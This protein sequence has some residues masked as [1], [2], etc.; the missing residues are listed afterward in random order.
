MPKMKDVASLAGVSPA[1][2]SRVLN[3][4]ANV[5][6]ALAERVRDA[7][8]QLDYRANGVARSLRLQRT[9]VW[10]LII[11]DIEN[12]F[13]TS[14]ARG[15]EDI[16]Q[17]E[18]F[19]VILCNTDGNPEKEARYLDVAEREQVSGVVISPNRSG[20]D[21]SRLMAA[22]IPIVAVDRHLDQPVDTVVVDSEHGA[23]EATR[24]LFEQGWNRPACVTGPTAT[25]T[26]EQRLEGY[27]RAW[28]AHRGRPLVSLVKHTD[29]NAETAR[30]A[31]ASLLRQANPPDSFFVANSLMALGALE[32]FRE[33][34]VVPGRDVGL[35]AFDDAPWA[36]FVDPPLSVV[37][38]P[39]YDMGCR[40]GELLLE[41]VRARGAV[42]PAET[43]V[44]ETSLVPRA[45]S[46]RSAPTKRGR[47]RP[48]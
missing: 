27:R 44:L 40:A 5:D 36:R 29:Y 45:S 38:Q 24:H 20:S 31:V 34:G 8:R 19:S 7:A 14:V 22:S 23:E 9:D 2:V 41:R 15:V 37:A 48:R 39:A 47:S 11:S 46:R 25:E 30:T 12:P 4:V 32:E 35:I 6:E 33:R 42:R 43:I 16:A 17:R 13:F 26:A 10:A 3:G 21:I 28:R 18:G 1:T